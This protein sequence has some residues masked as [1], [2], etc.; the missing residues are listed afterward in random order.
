[1]RWLQ[2]LL[3]FLTAYLH[4]AASP[5]SEALRSLVLIHFRQGTCLTPTYSEVRREVRL[6]PTRLAILAE[7][8]LFPV[9]PAK[10]PQG[11]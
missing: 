10:A 5:P 11:S 9:E 7:S 2:V 8:H 4:E 6:H 3:D 1:M